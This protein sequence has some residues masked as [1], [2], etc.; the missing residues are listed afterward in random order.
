M[1]VSLTIASTTPSDAAVRMRR[2]KHA[3]ARSTRE[4]AAIGSA[5]DSPPD[6]LHRVIG[7]SHM[8]ALLELAARCRGTRLA[9]SHCYPS[10]AA[11]RH[12]ADHG[13]ELAFGCCRVA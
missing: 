4:T 5:D 9:R 2:V 7:L 6:D 8:A 11:T 1:R 3:G 12:I 13:H 10:T